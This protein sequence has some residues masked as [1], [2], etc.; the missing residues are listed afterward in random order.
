MNTQEF[1]FHAIKYIIQALLLYIILN[2][3]PKQKLYINDIYTVTTLAIIAYVAINILCSNSN[4][5]KSFTQNLKNIYSN[6]NQ[7]F[8]E[9]MANVNNDQIKIKEKAQD[10]E[11]IA[12]EIGMK[13]AAGEITRE[14]AAVAAKA[15]ESQYDEIKS[16]EEEVQDDN[17]QMEQNYEE[18]EEVAVEETPLEKVDKKPAAKRV[19]DK[20]RKLGYKTN[21]NLIWGEDYDNDMAFNELPEDMM[22]PLGQIDTSYTFM[23]PWKWWPP[24]AR[25]P[26]CVSEKRCQPCPVTTIGTPVDVKDWDAS[27]HVTNGLGVNIEYIKKLNDIYN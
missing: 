4:I 8:V 10:I 9:N 19:N 1:T 23:P 5:T 11:A 6:N 17:V 7:H 27:R 3:V 14:E 15:L 22:K 20:S 24:R 18:K 16:E 12:Q 21:R 13:F 25:P 26:A 2:I